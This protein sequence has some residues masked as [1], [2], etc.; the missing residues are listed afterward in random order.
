M[1]VVGKGWTAFRTFGNRM[2]GEWS[3]RLRARRL[4][5]QGLQRVRDMNRR[6]EQ[7]GRYVESLAQG[8]DPSVFSV[9]IPAYHV[10]DFIEETLGTIVSQDMPEGVT[11]DVVVSVDGCTATR[12]AILAALRRMTPAQRQCVR[13]LMHE[14]NYG[15]Y[16][17]QNTALQAT[18]G[19]RVHI[20]GAD[21]ALAPG[22]LRKLWQFADECGRCSADFILRPMSSVC[23][24]QLQPKP[25]RDLHQHKGALVLSKGVLDKLGGLAPWMCAADSDFLRRAERKGILVFS[26]PE[27]TYLYRQHDKQLT[28]G[29]GTGMGSGVREAYWLETNARILRGRIFEPPVIAPDGICIEGGAVSEQ[30]TEPLNKNHESGSDSH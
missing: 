27:V 19:E 16:M 29:A 23:D 12:D 26:L 21:D 6:V 8:C 10:E 20:I 15:S 9:A 2:A 4:R 14:R 17:M 28:Q 5:Q 11:L 1:S 30:E 7:Y 18:R 22:A 3:N 25:G 13:M 24:A